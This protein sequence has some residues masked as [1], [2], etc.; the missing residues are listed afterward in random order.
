M[1]KK[2]EGFDK[3]WIN[4]QGRIY[5]DKTCK[6]LKCQDNGN[7]YKKITLTLKGVQIQRYIHRLVAI[8]FIPNPLD[9]PEV[10]HKD[11]NKANNNYTNLEW[12]N[13][14][15]NQ[16]HAHKTGLKPNGNKLWNGKF[17][18]DDIIKIKLLKDEGVLQYKIAELFNTTKST[19]SEILSGKRYRYQ[20]LYYALT[21]QELTIQ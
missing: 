10:N 5:N 1:I 2:I 19:I 7:G 3:Y 6:Y 11:G 16:I 9:L 13:N 12:V 15:E 14:S 20:N 17:S 8:S 21:G 18:E 4:G